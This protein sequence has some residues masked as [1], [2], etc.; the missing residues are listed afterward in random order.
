MLETGVIH[1]TEG[2]YAAVTANV[3]AAS[4]STGPPAPRALSEAEVAA[5][6]AWFEAYH[7]DM[8]AAAAEIRATEVFYARRL[9]WSERS[10]LNS[11][12]PRRNVANLLVRVVPPG[13]P[14]QPPELD[15][16][17]VS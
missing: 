8:P 13:T 9:Q 12:A 3:S 2:M 15:P 14:I 17:L 5:I 16:R 11:P 6:R 4:A 7:T 1:I 10:P